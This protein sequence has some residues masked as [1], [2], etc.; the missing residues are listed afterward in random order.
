M[1]YGED[2][3]SNLGKDGE[4]LTAVRGRHL[5][6]MAPNDVGSQPAATFFFP[7]QL[8]DC[9]WKFLILHCR[10]IMDLLCQVF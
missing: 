5:L 1:R 6:Q 7:S 9:F 2:K 8:F 10:I 4:T 3:Q